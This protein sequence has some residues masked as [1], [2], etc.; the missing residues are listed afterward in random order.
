MKEIAAKENGRPINIPALGAVTR[1]LVAKA[2]QGDTKTGL[3]LI[4]LGLRMD[5]GPA[6]SD[7]ETTPPE[8]AAIIAAAFA[9]RR[10]ADGDG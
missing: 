2:I 1:T 9:R 4:D 6:S 7:D 8:D 10:K 5:T 3:S